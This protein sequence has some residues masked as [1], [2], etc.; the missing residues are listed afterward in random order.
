MVSTHSNH[1]ILEASQRDRLL[2]RLAA[3]IGPAGVAARNSA[4]ALFCTKD[5]AG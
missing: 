1:L 2:A 3:F 5:G 4:L